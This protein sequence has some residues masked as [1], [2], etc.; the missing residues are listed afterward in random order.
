MQQLHSKFLFLLIATLLAVPYSM[1][2]QKKEADSVHYWLDKSIQ[3]EKIDT[4]DFQKGINKLNRL[5]LN[6]SL[7]KLFEE[8]ARKFPAGIEGYWRYLILQSLLNNLSSYDMDKAIVFGR[9]IFEETEKL[10]S[11]HALH[12]RNAFLIQLRLPYRNSNHIKE[13]FAFFT[14]MLKMY[15][16]KN[17]SAGLYCCHYV[18]GG[19]YRTIG[20]IDQAIYHC[21]KSKI[22]TNSAY[23]PE[24]SFGSFGYPNGY[25]QF[26]NAD[27]ITGLYLLQKEEYGLAI[28][29]IR[30][31]LSLFLDSNKVFLVVAPTVLAQAQMKQGKMDSV[32]YLMSKVV[33]I[34]TDFKVLA[35]QILAE[36]NILK[37]NTW[38][39]DSVLNI[40]DSLILKNRI[41]VTPSSG[42]IDPDYYRALVRAKLNQ[43]PE[44]IAYMKKD[45]V[46]L[47][48]NRP[49]IMR[50][51]RLLAQWYKQLNQPVQE[52]ETYHQFVGLQDGLLADQAQFRNL[53]FEAEQE[54]NAKELSIN[55]LQSANKISS[56][57]RNFSIGMAVLLLLMALGIYQRFRFKNKANAVLESTLTNLKSTQSQLIQAEK[58]ASLGELTAGIAHEI[59]NPLNFVNNFSEVS[60]ELIDEM[61]TEFKKGDTQ[62]GF[63]IADD[64]KQNLEKILHH[65]KRADAIVKGMLQHSRSTNNATKEPTDI[66]ALADE[67]LRLAY[68]GLR[69]KDKSFNAIMKTD[70]DDNIGNI[71]II[72]QDIGRVILNLITNAFYAVDEKKKL[73]QAEPAYRTGR[74]IEADY[75][76]TVSV[77]TKKLNDKLEIKV[78]DN[79][80]GIPQKV[81]DK[82][83]QPFFTTKPTGQGTGLGLS[84]SYDI[85]K[86]HGGE[87]KVETKESEG[88]AFIIQIPIQ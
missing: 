66:N 71:N 22:Y 64:I 10:K 14:E 83:F 42:V 55:S 31:P 20:L 1:K 38:A 73:C 60:N 15:R 35:L 81:L 85:V 26:Y 74:L 80:N 39:A 68:H 8:K 61:K 3:G 12:I 57:T 30:K 29:N 77:S 18:L 40:C 54:M 19:F 70:F 76:P 63:A 6:D 25:T 47:N 24:A 65:G 7:I 46:R 37:G 11:S 78:I 75:E 88:T 34:S 43:L 48:N 36:F 33:L 32:E 84:M 52:A 21:K 4:A 5:S 45:I 23:G 56:L 17:D 53:S 59:Q 69:A 82:I 2:A 49:L 27:V 50:D 58:M 67:Y 44:A 72:P 9:R 41:P 51:L 86:A 16:E 28:L 62:E 79:G 13:G 87:L